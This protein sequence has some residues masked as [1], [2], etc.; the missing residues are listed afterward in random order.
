MYNVCVRKMYLD[1]RELRLHRLILVLFGLWGSGR[2]VEQER[3]SCHLQTGPL[4]S[5]LWSQCLLLAGLWGRLWVGYMSEGASGKRSE[6]T[7]YG[8]SFTAS[9]LC[10]SATRRFASAIRR[11]MSSGM[12]G[13]GDAAFDADAD[14][15]LDDAGIGVGAAVAGAELDADAD[16]FI[17]AILAAISALFWAMRASAD[18]FEHAR[19]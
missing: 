9:L 2:G 1:R 13:D 5:R 19:D 10:A 17:A 3:M 18:S 16:F 4:L 11:A 15:T 8:L 7:M 12:G 14:A 6:R